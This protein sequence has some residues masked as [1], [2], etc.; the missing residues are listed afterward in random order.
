M[1]DDFRE[2]FPYM[3]LLVAIQSSAYGALIHSAIVTAFSE[4]WTVNAVH[5]L[6]EGVDFI[7]A[8]DVSAIVLDGSLA[9][10]SGI[11]GSKKSCSA[12]LGL[13][14]LLQHDR[15]LPTFVLLPNKQVDVQRLL[16]LGSFV[17][18]APS[19]T[20]WKELR[21]RI[22]LVLEHGRV[23]DELRSVSKE[24]QLGRVTSNDEPLGRSTSNEAS[25]PHEDFSW[26]PGVNEYD[27]VVALPAYREVMARFERSFLEM[28]LRLARGRVS[29]LA[30][31]LGMPV[32]TLRDRL[33]RYG[34]TP[35]D[36]R[37]EF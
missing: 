14:S 3:K 1:S 32:R 22:A 36:F 12:F 27:N 15:N 7:K 33:E 17:D 23:L 10:R 24:A 8:N 28:A 4:Q 9:S 26:E 20:P 31:K 25:S 2:R 5:G 30:R 35:K 11:V 21:S 37:D 19:D 29:G 34:L 6:E 18:G 16:E 13:S